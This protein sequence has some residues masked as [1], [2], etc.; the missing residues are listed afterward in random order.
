MQNDLFGLVN[1]F[2][3]FFPILNVENIFSFIIHAFE[4]VRLRH[5]R[6]CQIVRKAPEISRYK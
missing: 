2:P 5:S 4:S 1:S 6:V 3:G